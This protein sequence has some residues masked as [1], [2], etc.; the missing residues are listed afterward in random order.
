M[1]PRLDER[2]A[3]KGACPDEIVVICGTDGTPMIWARFGA[4]A[5]QTDRYE[6][7]QIQEPRIVGPFRIGDLHTDPSGF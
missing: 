1:L 7:P 2:L 4:A 5:K 6:G 3:D